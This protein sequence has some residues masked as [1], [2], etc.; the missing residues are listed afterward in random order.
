[1]QLTNAQ[2][3][4][5]PISILWYRECWSIQLKCTFET[6]QER[7][8]LGLRMMTDD[9]CKPDL[10]TLGSRQSLAIWHIRSKCAEG[11]VMPDI[12]HDIW[13]CL[14]SSTHWWV[15]R[16][17]R[18][19]ALPNAIVYFSSPQ[20]QTSILLIFAYGLICIAVYLSLVRSKHVLGWTIM[21]MRIASCRQCTM[22]EHGT[23]DNSM[24]TIWILDTKNYLH[25]CLSRSNIHNNRNVQQDNM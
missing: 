18:M 8:I 6:K 17:S 14:A 24:T 11:S 25:F 21:T 5:A 3:Q 13:H 19:A 22:D 16:W 12:S 23:R 7:I 15:W 1:M 4:T 2:C 20:Y 10:V 9:C